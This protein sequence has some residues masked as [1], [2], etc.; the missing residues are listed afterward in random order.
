MSRRSVGAPDAAPGVSSD[1][2]LEGSQPGGVAAD[3]MPSPDARKALQTQRLPPGM[4]QRAQS[5]AVALFKRV[6][7]RASGS[8]AQKPAIMSVEANA[9]R[10][11]AE[12]PRSASQPDDM[13]A[14][15]ATAHIMP[16]RRSGSLSAAEAGSDAERAA[17]R[18]RTDGAPHKRAGQKPPNGARVPVAAHLTSADRSTSDASAPGSQEPDLGGPLLVRNGSSLGSRR[19]GPAGAKPKGG[20][21]RLSSAGSA[22]APITSLIEGRCSWLGCSSVVVTRHDVQGEDMPAWPLVTRAAPG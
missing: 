14:D 9:V 22:A 2:A 8:S 6:R 3:E 20:R 10:C 12:R 7:G 13:P 16:D 15:H 1:E 21:R 18:R 4:R 17:K 19:H 11:A 5:A